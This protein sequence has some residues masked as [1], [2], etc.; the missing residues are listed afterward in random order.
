[1]GF[2]M[3]HHLVASFIADANGYNAVIVTAGRS[4]VISGEPFKGTNY[5][6]P[7][8]FTVEKSHLYHKSTVELDEFTN[9]SN[10]AMR[11]TQHV[12]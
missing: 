6:N 5:F 8:R 9:P 2:D 1:M 7:K 4:I 12:S 11:I 3:W 10:I